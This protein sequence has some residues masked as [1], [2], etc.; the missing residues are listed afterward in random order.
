MRFER[1]N[2][3]LLIFFMII[4]MKNKFLQKQDLFKWMLNL[5]SKI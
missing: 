2:N 5:K 1:E 4:L 3:M